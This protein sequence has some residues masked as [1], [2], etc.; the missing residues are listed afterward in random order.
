MFQCRL[1]TG[2]EPL[3]C[4]PNAQTVC[5]AVSLET[6][7]FSETPMDLLVENPE[8][9]T[10][11]LKGREIVVGKCLLRKDLAPRGGFELATLRLTASRVILPKLAGIGLNRRQSASCDETRRVL[12]PFSTHLLFTLCRHLPRLA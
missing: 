8:S 2:F 9:R 12:F 1:A 11:V 5:I 10:T 4:E 6:L 7:V 3:G